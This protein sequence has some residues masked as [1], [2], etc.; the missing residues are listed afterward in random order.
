MIFSV[1]RKNYN[2]M[3]QS[4]NFCFK[5]TKKIKTEDIFNDKVNYDLNII[6]DDK[7]NN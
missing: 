5:I 1:K 7:L 4:F 3:N 6:N 2:E